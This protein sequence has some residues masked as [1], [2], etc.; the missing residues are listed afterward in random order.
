MRDDR[1]G[2]GGK[3][4]IGQCD[5]SHCRTSHCTH[6]NE[7]GRRKELFDGGFCQVPKYIHVGRYHFV[8]LR[9]SIVKKW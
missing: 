6:S 8:E 5:R 1:I 2:K 3:V 7:F 4:M 9:T